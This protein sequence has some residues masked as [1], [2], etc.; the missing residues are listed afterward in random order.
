MYDDDGRHE[1]SSSHRGL[2]LYADVWMEG[3]E[4]GDTLGS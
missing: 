4:E 1:T 2:N 3:Y